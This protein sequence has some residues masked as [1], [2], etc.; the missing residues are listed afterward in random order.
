V[1]TL[2][3]NHVKQ[4]SSRSSNGFSNRKGIIGLILYSNGNTLDDE[5]RTT[6]GS[7]F[8]SNNVQLSSP[9]RNIDV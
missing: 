7:N 3:G 4:P 5:K 9:K 6:L 8:L 1:A 2:Y